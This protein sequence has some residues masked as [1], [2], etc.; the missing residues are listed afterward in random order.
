[1]V[2]VSTVGNVT[3][4]KTTAVRIIGATAHIIY[5]QEK[6]PNTNVHIIYSTLES[7]GVSPLMLATL[8]FVQTVYVSLICMIFRFLIYFERCVVSGEHAFQEFPKV[9]FGM[10]L[11]TLLNGAGLG[12]AIY[13]GVKAGEADNEDDLNTGTKLRRIGAVLFVI[14][15]AFIVLVHGFLWANRSKVL[16]AR[17]KVSMIA[18]SQ[19]VRGTG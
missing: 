18:L 1:M 4:R 11:L 12:L 16:I 10:R 3:E 2:V 19:L 7:A 5:E 14:L 8:G 13:G 6:T 17:R 15:Y 9:K